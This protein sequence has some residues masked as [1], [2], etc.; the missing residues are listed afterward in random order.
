MDNV[1]PEIRALFAE[2]HARIDALTERVAQLEATRRPPAVPSTA[3][4]DAVAAEQKAAQ[5]ME[6]NK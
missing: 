5:A 3:D 2:A 4:L 1:H 6:E